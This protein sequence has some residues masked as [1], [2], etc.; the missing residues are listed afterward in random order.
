MWQILY[1][2][3]LEDWTYHKYWM[4]SV[5]KT[6]VI[7]WGPYPL[8]LVGWFCQDPYEFHWTQSIQNH[9][10]RQFSHLW[11]TLK[12]TSLTIASAFC[13]LTDEILLL[14]LGW[15]DLTDEEASS[16]LDAQIDGDDICLC[17][18]FLYHGCFFHNCVQGLTMIDLYSCCNRPCPQYEVL[19]PCAAGPLPHYNLI[20]EED[21]RGGGV[22]EKITRNFGDDLALVH[23]RIASCPLFL[24]QPWKTLVLCNLS[25]S[26]LNQAC[27]SLEDFVKVQPEKCG[28]TDR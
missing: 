2:L 4:D 22:H 19:P 3:R 13:W 6:V 16:I 9:T 21:G 28:W 27:W 5:K 23:P 20:K 14:R 18:N 15:S 17:N 24:W 7:H 1:F 25:G 26:R 12:D 10:N 11:E 8:A